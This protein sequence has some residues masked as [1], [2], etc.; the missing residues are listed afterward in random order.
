[1]ENIKKRK[2]LQIGTLDK[3]KVLSLYYGS[4]GVRLIPKNQ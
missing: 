4:L 3:G 1:M 2:Q